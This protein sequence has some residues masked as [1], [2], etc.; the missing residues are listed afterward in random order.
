MSY[1]YYFGKHNENENIIYQN[2]NFDNIVV[3]M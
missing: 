2:I 1:Q 3:I